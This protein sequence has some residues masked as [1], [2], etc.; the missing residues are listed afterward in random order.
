MPFTRRSSDSQR[1]SR[2]IIPFLFL[3]ITP[4]RARRS[5]YSGGRTLKEERIRFPALSDG[6]AASF[7]KLCIALR[8]PQIFPHERCIY[9]CTPTYG[10]FRL[11]LPYTVPKSA[12]SS[13]FAQIFATAGQ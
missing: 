6:P 11:L 7:E 8:G 4:V 5:Y 1:F 13:H 12:M 2:Q 3:D 9:N 10:D